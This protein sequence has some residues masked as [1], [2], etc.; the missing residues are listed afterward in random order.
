MDELIR[1]GHDVRILTVSEKLKSHVEG[2][3]CLDDVLVDGR[4]GFEYEAEEEFCSL[5]D[6]ILQNP[7]WC[8]S[9]GVQSVQNASNFDKTVFAQKIESVYEHI[10]A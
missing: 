4:N 5:L 2:N 10:I 1:K 8:Q 3:A 6:T 9:A 7:D